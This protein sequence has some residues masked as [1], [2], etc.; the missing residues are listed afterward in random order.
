MWADVGDAQ[1]GPLS[2]KLVCV[3]DHSHRHRSSPETAVARAECEVSPASCACQVTAEILLQTLE[4]VAN[5][6]ERQ[7]NRGRPVQVGNTL[8]LQKEEASKW[9]SQWEKLQEN[10]RAAKALLDYLEQAADCV[11][12]QAEDVRASTPSRRRRSKSAAPAAAAGSSQAQVGNPFQQGRGGACP[13]PGGVQVQAGQ[14]SNKTIRSRAV[15]CSEAQPVFAG[16]SS[17]S[18][19]GP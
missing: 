17:A 16:C 2:S 7:A 3:W 6:L 5:R 12:S 11:A 9:R 8:P 14:R 4:S 18:H 10:E 19:S 13:R 1:P 15:R